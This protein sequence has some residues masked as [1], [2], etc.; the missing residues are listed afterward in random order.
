MFR[1]IAFLSFKN[2]KEVMNE[3]QR[4]ID[5]Q[6]IMVQIIMEV[7]WPLLQPVTVLLFVK[8]L[9]LMSK[10]LFVKSIFIFSK[11]KLIH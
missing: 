10:F 8:A 4:R 1:E 7:N 11:K 9:Y 5:F 2:L 3:T 6:F